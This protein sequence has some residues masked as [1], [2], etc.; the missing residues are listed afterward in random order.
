VKYLRTWW[1]L[2]VGL[3]LV[4]YGFVFLAGTVWLYQRHAL[5]YWVGAT[6]VVTLVAFGVA[7]WLRS[8]S[9]QPIRADVQPDPHWSPK[10]EAAWARVEEI[11]SRA[12]AEPLE[13]QNGEALASRLML[14]TREILD[15]VAAAYRPKYRNAAL[16]VPITHVLAIVELAARDLRRQISRNLPLSH[17][18][19]LNDF[20]RLP[21]LS[22]L[23]R[24]LY[25]IY[26]VV[27]FGWNP[28]AA[29]PRELVD[30]VWNRN[31]SATFEEASRW[32]IG[33][34]AQ[35]IGYY[36]IQLYSGHLVVGDEEFAAFRTT[37][38][39]DQLT[40]SGER[41]HFEQGEPLRILIMGQ[42]KAGKSSLI[43]ALFGEVKAAT[44][45]VPRTAGVE[46][47]AIE[48]EGAR[49]AVI[50]DTAGYDE[51]RRDGPSARKL[52]DEI[53]H[54][55][56][57]LMVVSAVSAARESDRQMLDTL[58]ELFRTQPDRSLPPL[59]VAVSHIDLLRPVREWNPPYDLRNDD[60]TK[61][62]HIR[63]SVAAVA[64]ELGVEHEAV[65]PVCLADGKTYNVTEA[66]LPAL[67]H[68]LPEAERARCLR[69]LPEFRRGQRWDLLWDQAIRAGRLLWKFG[70]SRLPDDAANN[71]PPGR[72]AHRT[73]APAGSSTRTNHDS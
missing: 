66:L 53:L 62:R 39:D 55:D 44:D 63:Q 16:E 6:G 3:L 22:A 27:R 34:F 72:A 49:Q 51:I 54:A 57:A 23:S 48:I 9:L 25:T 1:L 52:R 37:R 67:L 38:S 11:A 24:R 43:N 35:K 15:S 4:P 17:I 50:L 13:W 73:S 12:K 70:V 20:R 65:V 29:V 36:A 41:E 45:V 56:V 42:V 8:K 14:L 26:R 32:A 69:L 33:Y 31:Q 60:D 18:L 58:R 61:A 64:A 21:Q 28:A 7:E 40:R 10:G 30:A 19:T 46:P 47:F 71:Q 59:V 2:I 68:V 5:W